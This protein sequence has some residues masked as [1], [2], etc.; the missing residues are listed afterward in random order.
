MSENILRLHYKYHSDN[1][2]YDNTQHSFRES[3]KP[4]KCDD[5]ERNIEPLIFNIVTIAK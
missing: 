1:K 5:D 4:H 2:I 3:Y